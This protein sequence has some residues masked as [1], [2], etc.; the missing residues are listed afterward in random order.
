MDVCALLK[1]I[2]SII[3]LWLFLFFI[4]G[5]E[6]DEHCVFHATMCIAAMFGIVGSMLLLRCYYE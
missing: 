6:G 1:I 4:F 2:G 5:V 3:A